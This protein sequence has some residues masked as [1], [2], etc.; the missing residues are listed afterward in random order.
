[1]YINVRIHAFK[2]TNHAF[3][4]AKKEGEKY[5]LWI[6]YWQENTTLNG[7]IVHA[8]LWV[9]LESEHLR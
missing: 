8:G 6:W 5:A 2:D 4:T 7:R 9:I 3:K 1:M